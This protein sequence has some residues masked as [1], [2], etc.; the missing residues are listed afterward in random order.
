MTEVRLVY[1]PVPDEACGREIGRRLVERGLAACANILP[2]MTS[3]Y[4][5]EGKLEEDRES[6]LLAKTTAEAAVGGG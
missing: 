1:I 5:W 2:R 6:L 3:I 4:R